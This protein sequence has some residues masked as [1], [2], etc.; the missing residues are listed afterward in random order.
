MEPIIHQHIWLTQSGRLRSWISPYFFL[1]H[2]LIVFLCCTPRSVTSY[3]SRVHFTRR[4]NQRFSPVSSTISP[5]SLITVAALHRRTSR[6]NTGRRAT[7]GS[8]WNKFV[9]INC[10]FSLLVANPHSKISDATPP[11]SPGDKSHF[12][13]AADNPVLDFWWYLWVSKPGSATLFMLGRGICVT[14]VPSDS[15][16]V[17]YQQTSW[18]AEWQPSR[19]LPYTCKQALV[20]LETGTYHAAAH[21]VRPGRCFTDW[22]ML[23]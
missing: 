15:P 9:K 8:P 13:G 19:S 18:W 11:P 20:G 12:C 3:T 21:G 2:T 16:L 7:R 5:V 22:P 10:W 14:H 23:A 6:E 17:W 4:P 1:D